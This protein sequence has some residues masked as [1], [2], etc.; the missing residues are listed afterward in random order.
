MK[1]TEV[2]HQEKENY[3]QLCESLY[4]DGVIKQDVDG[5]FVAVEDPIEREQIK[6]KSK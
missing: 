6:S 2:I 5:S 3:R 1:E 4:I